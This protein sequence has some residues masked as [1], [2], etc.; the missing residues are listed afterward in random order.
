MALLLQLVFFLSVEVSA[1][2]TMTSSSEPFAPKTGTSSPL[3]TDTIENVYKVQ[4]VNFLVEIII[5]G[6]S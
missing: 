4:P 3:A 1:D 6:S 2:C 5:V